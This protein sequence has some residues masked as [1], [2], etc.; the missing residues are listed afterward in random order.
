[1]KE[2]FFIFVKSTKANS[3]LNSFFEEKGESMIATKATDIYKNSYDGVWVD[4]QG[5]DLLL[6]NVQNLKNEIDFR[7]Y[8]R[9]KKAKEFV[10][11]LPMK[12]IKFEII[13]KRRKN[14]PSVR[15]NLKKTIDQIQKK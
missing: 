15:I 4:V 9:L 14:T 1:M 11:P 13:G 10:R 5:K 2:D 7:I 6:S 12:R 3:I 8:V